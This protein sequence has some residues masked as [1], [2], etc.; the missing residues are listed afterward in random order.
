M[1]LCQEEGNFNELPRVLDRFFIPDNSHSLLLRRSADDDCNGHKHGISITGA[2]SGKL[3]RVMDINNLKLSIF[4]MI[5]PVL[6]TFLRFTLSICSRILYTIKIVRHSDDGTRNG[7][8]A[9][10]YKGNTS[11]ELYC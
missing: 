5:H 6:S 8:R 3:E 1:W 7:N 10:Y 9:R 4:L 11:C 2:I